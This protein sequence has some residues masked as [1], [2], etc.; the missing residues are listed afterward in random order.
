MGHDEWPLG[1]SRC[2]EAGKAGHDGN[3]GLLA[4]IGEQGKENRGAS[5]RDDLSRLQKG[6][7]ATASLVDVAPDVG[8]AEKREDT[9]L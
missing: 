9:N 7:S 2:Q 8:V 4:H 3:V 5:T 6:T 1:Q